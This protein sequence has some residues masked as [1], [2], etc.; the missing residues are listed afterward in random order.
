MYLREIETREMASWSPILDMLEPDP[1]PCGLSEWRIADAID[2]YVAGQRAL[3]ARRTSDRE[4]VRAALNAV[5]Y[6]YGFR[7]TSIPGRCHDR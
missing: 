2:V 7:I 5:L 3:A 6:A 1:E 4:A